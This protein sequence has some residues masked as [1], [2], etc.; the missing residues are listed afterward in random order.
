MLSRENRTAASRFQPSW[1][2]DNGRGIV[3]EALGKIFIPFYSTK[4]EGSGIGLSLSRQIMRLHY[5]DLIAESEPGE[6]T[7]LTMRF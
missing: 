7:V 6:R 1:T 3:E 5:G 2:V 4:K